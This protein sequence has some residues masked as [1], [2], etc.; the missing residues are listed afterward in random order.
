MNSYAFLRYTNK[1]VNGQTTVYAILLKWQADNNVILG[2]P[3]PSSQTTVVSMLGYKSGTKFSWKPAATPQG[4]EIIVPAL[5]EI[6][7]PCKWAWVFKLEGLQN[8]PAD[9]AKPIYRPEFLIQQPK[10]HF[11]ETFF[12]EN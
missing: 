4:M 9:P 7:L 10:H 12:P 3:I 2:A 1:T 8:K 11:Y 6:A 5:P